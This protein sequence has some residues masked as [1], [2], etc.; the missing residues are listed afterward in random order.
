MT[1]RVKAVTIKNGMLVFSGIKVQLTTNSMGLEFITF[2]NNK[3][4]ILAVH[5]SGEL[6]LCSGAYSS[7]EQSLIVNFIQDHI[8]SMMALD[9]KYILRYVSIKQLSG[10]SLFYDNVLLNKVIK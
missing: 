5:N 6:K 10:I 3:N 7:R 1:S 4:A 8:I 2:Y 9:Y